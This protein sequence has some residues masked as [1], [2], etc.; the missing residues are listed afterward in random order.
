M[1]GEYMMSHRQPTYNKTAEY[2]KGNEAGREKSTIVL[3]HAIQLKKQK[4]QERADQEAKETIKD[5]VNS[6][7]KARMRKNTEQE[8]TTQGNEDE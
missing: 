7:V 8:Q 4:A 5:Q 3:D 2:F 1:Y 6:I